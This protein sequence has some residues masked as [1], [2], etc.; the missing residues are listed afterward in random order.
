LNEAETEFVIALRESHGEFSDAA[1]NLK[2]C[3]ALLSTAKNHDK[4]ADLKLVRD[5]R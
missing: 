5:V 1:H 2:L 3:R 4:M